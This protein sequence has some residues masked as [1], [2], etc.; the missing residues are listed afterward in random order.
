MD[1]LKVW[2]DGLTEPRNPGGYSCYGWV[3]LD[4]SD[5][6]Q[7]HGIGCLGIGEGMTNN[8][9]EYQA[10][11]SV[12]RWLNEFGY[13]QVAIFSDS[14][15]VVNQVAGAWKCNKPQLQVRRRVARELWHDDYTLT[16]VP[17]EQ[18]E[19]ADALSHVAYAKA[20]KL[21]TATKDAK[22]DEVEDL[23]SPV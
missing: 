4:E 17:R 21:L 3:A 15:L 14:Q 2:V 9:A 12:L 16:W 1:K 5:V 13:T 20:R 11:I 7:A 6:E 22:F 18:N 10:L 19:R 8:L 23:R